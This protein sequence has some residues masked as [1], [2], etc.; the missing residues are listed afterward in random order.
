MVL[1]VLVLVLGLVGAGAVLL[2]ASVAGGRSEGFA[3]FVAD[4]RAGLR[5]GG[6]DAQSFED[7]SDEPVLAVPTQPDAPLGDA[8]VADPQGIDALFLGTRPT[9]GYVDYEELSQTLG[10]AT[11][12]AARGVALITRR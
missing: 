4:L 11:Q 3:Q 8:P 7:Q 10:L 12:R 5:G 2:V 6:T 1:V 9:P